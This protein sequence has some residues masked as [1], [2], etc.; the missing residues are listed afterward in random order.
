MRAA[1]AEA[2]VGD[3][4]F[5]DDPT[6]RQ[7][8][9][10]LAE[11]VGKE[12]AI[13]VP[14]GTMSN[15]IAVRLHCQPGDEILC[16]AGCHIYNYEQG[17]AAQL[18]GVSVR[19]VAGQE[20]LLRLADLEGLIRPDNEH[21]VR[22]RLVALENTHNRG[23]G[24]ILPLDEVERIC[25]WAHEHG[26]LTHLDGARLFNA[27]V[28]SGVAAPVWCRNFDTVS[29]CF[30]KGLGAPVGSALAGTKRHIALARRHRKLFGGGMRQVGILAAGALY[31]LEHHVARLAD[32]HAHAQL[33][34][35]TIRDTPGL[36]LRPRQVDTNLV[37]FHVDPALGTSVEF[38]KQLEERGLGV[39]AFGPTLIRACTHLDASRADIEE[40]CRILRETAAEAKG[41]A[42]PKAA[43]LGTAY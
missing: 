12:A 2:E 1:M 18:S 38:V 3:D 33:L 42:R 43:A 32:D 11:M 5:G 17:G 10:R 16:E 19:A 36:E 30:S 20:S 22:T 6:V 29:I 4:V 35:Q 14:S 40:A 7:L 41:G 37:I 34:A 21:L 23:G 28:A 8:E 27:V 39:I 26:L 24:R 31:A 9:E 13:F 25:S 15:Q